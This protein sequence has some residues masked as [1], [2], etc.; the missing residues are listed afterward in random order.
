MVGNAWYW[1]WD[2]KPPWANGPEASWGP[3]GP[4]RPAGPQGTMASDR[5][6]KPES[7][8]LPSTIFNQNLNWILTV[9]L[10]IFNVFKTIIII[11]M[12]MT[13]VKKMSGTLKKYFLNTFCHQEWGEGFLRLRTVRAGH[14]CLIPKVFKKCF[15]N[16]RDIFLKFLLTFLS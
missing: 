15:F 4:W 7:G 1:P 9:F 8:D 13:N 11:K 10:W 14:P 16:V 3:I 6:L 2:M 12:S 5:H